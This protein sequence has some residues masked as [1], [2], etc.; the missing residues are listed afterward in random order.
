MNA[1]EIRSHQVVDYLK[2]YIAELEEA[3]KTIQKS[4]DDIFDLGSDMYRELEI[5]DISNTGELM[6]TR[7]ILSVVSGILGIQLEEK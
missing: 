5:E 7:K 2:K 1:Y 6:A 3:D 4:L